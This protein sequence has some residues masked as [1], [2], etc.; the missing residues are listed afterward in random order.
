MSIQEF[1]A[2]FPAAQLAREERGVIDEAI[3]WIEQFSELALVDGL[4]NIH[5]SDLIHGQIR[6]DWCD[7]RKSEVEWFDDWASIAGIGVGT[8]NVGGVQVYFIHTFTPP[9]GDTYRIFADNPCVLAQMGYDVQVVKHGRIIPREHYAAKPTAVVAPI[10]EQA[11][12]ATP[13]AKRRFLVLANHAPYQGDMR[14][15]DGGLWVCTGTGQSWRMGDNSHGDSSLEGEMVCYAYY[16][17]ATAEQVE[18]HLQKLAQANTKLN[19]KT[20]LK[21]LADVVKLTGQ[22]ADGVQ[23][24]EVLDTRPYYTGAGYGV[25]DVWYLDG[26]TLCLAHYTGSDVPEWEWQYYTTA[27]VA[28]VAMLKELAAK[29]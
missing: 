28:L 24:C 15:L 4:K 16:I 12:P 10:A 6:L 5:P 20:R 9:D 7:I 17:P 14:E 29:E 27:D 18:S 1:N 25:G 11:Q 8:T 19:Y 21:S 23:G 3:Q 26:D 2:K 13:P 22:T